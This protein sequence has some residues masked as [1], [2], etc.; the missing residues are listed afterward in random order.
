MDSG[1]RIRLS[2][3]GEAG[4]NG[5]P[6]GDLYVQVE[7]DDHPIFTREGENLYCEVPISFVSAALG[8]ELEVPTLEGRVN[9][10][11]PS[12]TQTGR[13]FR[14][15]GKGVD[16]TKVRGGGVGDLYCR[17]AVETPV[18]LSRKQ[19]ELLQEFAEE[20]SDKQSPKQA[21]WFKGVKNFIESLT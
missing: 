21:S 2:G 4:L 20:S 7:V 17:I 8:G 13:L 9:L 11:I 16:V 19:K 3:Q 15:R 18:N 10:K 12:E 14:L 6:P 1:D 5:G